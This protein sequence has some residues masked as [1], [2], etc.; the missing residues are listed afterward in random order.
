[1][2]TSELMGASG[3]AS[4]V[5]RRAFA[6]ALSLLLAAAVGVAG[7]GSAA[8]AGSPVSRRSA[9]EAG[10]RVALMLP[11]P[12]DFTY[13]VAQ[14]RIT[15]RPRATRSTRTTI[16]HGDT[17]GLS[18]VASSPA[19][20]QLRRS[21]HVY[22]V[23]STVKGAGGSVRDVYF[24]VTRRRGGKTGP[25]HGTIGFSIANATPQTHSFWVRGIDR[26]RDAVIFSSVNAV[27][28]AVRNWSR[29]LAV[30]KLAHALMA[31]AHPVDANGQF[32]SPGGTG[33]ARA[34][35]AR[36]ERAAIARATSHRVRHGR[37][38]AHGTR[39]GTGG[40]LKGVWQ[41]GQRPTRDVMGIFD[42]IFGTIGNR[43][44]FQSA[45]DSPLVPI[46]ITRD[47]NNRPLANRLTALL[48]LLPIEIPDRY[49]AAAQ[50]EQRFSKGAIHAPRI[51]AARVA[52]ADTTN[53]ASQ[54]AIDSPAPPSGGSIAG[55]EV[56]VHFVGS[57]QGTV[58]K[59]LRVG[60][61]SYG[62]YDTDF[63]SG[64]DCSSLCTG[65]Y[66]DGQHL[67]LIADPAT[68]SAFQGWQGCNGGTGGAQSSV[69]D[70]CY[71]V[72]G[73]GAT[74]NLYARYEPATNTPSTAT[75]AVSLTGTGSGT[76]ASTPAG[77]NCPTTCGAAFTAGTPVSLQAT[78]SAG[79]TF[80]GWTG[81]DSASGATCSVAM[82]AD[83]TVS[84]RF[85]KA[86]PAVPAGSLDTTFG[87]NGITLTSLNTNGG[88]GADRIV[89]QS[90]GKFVVVGTAIDGSGNAQIEVARYTSTGALDTS[91]GTNGIAALRPNGS[92]QVLL[93]PSLA[94][95]PSGDIV[96][97]GT[98]NDPANV[99][100][101]KADFGAERLTASGSFDSG[102]GTGGFVDTQV[103]AAASDVAS[104]VLVNPSSGE[105][106][107]G[108]SS[109]PT[110]ADNAMALAAYTAS[111]APDTSFGTS[112][113]V[114]TPTSGGGS[115][116]NAL[117]FDG[118]EIVGAGSFFDSGTG[119]PSVAAMRWSASGLADS[120]FNGGKP[121]TLSLGTN[122]YAHA[123][124]VQ[125][126]HEIVVGG[127]GSY[128]GGL[129]CM[130]LGRFNADGSR[131]TSFGTGGDAHV[132]PGTAS[133]D[134]SEAYGLA[135]G[136]DG[137]YI[138]AAGN[139]FINSTTRN[140]VALA[141]FTAN[142]ALDSSFGS[143]GYVTSDA[144]GAGNDSNANAIVV[145]GSNPVIAGQA[146][147]NTSHT[148]YFAL[149]RFTG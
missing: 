38:H 53:A 144:A 145:D 127:F 112:G 80:A 62:G 8:R 1:M 25:G 52:I 110:G 117:A 98:W 35:L 23:V 89:R 13:G 129:F 12:G 116:I 121:S 81:C 128:P 6:A 75:L 46:F 85:D 114:Q 67:E 146:Y 65:F 43:L 76:V 51:S 93:G 41:G 77:V 26:H 141:R 73:H 5:R 74:M 149:E 105:I 30:L 4:P 140:S 58:H 11:H 66:P 103:G 33:A 132:C 88:D 125:S 138:Y 148:T 22:V 7:S 84:A 42:L 113:T 134:D 48:A 130:A 15:G 135:A 119:L 37:G 147:N 115:A 14:V 90:D 54:A 78:A 107:I 50:E 108:G 79:S 86:A 101:A 63:S 142:G 16:F 17:G 55:E 72:V 131:D 19:W 71:V 124:L 20:R 143:G 34:V 120:S 111:G 122:S 82:S 39:H 47:L 83:R 136:P 32:R 21:T 102:F 118:S 61:D 31:A 137:S 56:V 99:V 68:G 57:G 10:T 29:Y 45:K 40:G 49:A 44:A 97:A 91:F 59:Y 133:G 104:A 69:A 96:V 92:G 64:V 24:F 18:I 123:V 36:A 28:T 106:Y 94:L 70:K 87:T 27:S 139:S 109:E 3:S 2:R 95:Q 126:N 60:P 100:I 9:R